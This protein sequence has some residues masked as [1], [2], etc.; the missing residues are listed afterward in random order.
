VI[1]AIFGLQYL[2]FWFYLIIFY[3]PGMEHQIAE[4]ESVIDPNLYRFHDPSDA[5]KY[6]L[7]GLLI[8]S[9]I[10]LAIG[11]VFGLRAYIEK[12]KFKVELTDKER[13]ILALIIVLLTIIVSFKLLYISNE[14]PTVPDIAFIELDE[15]NNSSLWIITVE[16]IIG[17]N[18]IELENTI[19]A[20]ERDNVTT[21]FYYLN[22][23]SSSLT[24][25][26]ITYVDTNNSQT[27]D[28]GDTFAFDKAIFN[29]NTKIRLIDSENNIIM[30]EREF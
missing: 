16:A 1:I 17:K 11:I 28:V 20:I 7:L 18:E 21:D 27:L 23:T 8:I 9:L 19:L 12:V 24:Y 15:V 5:L 25:R 29:E 22:Q 30:V 13:R 26:G 2:I 6:L 4:K 14:L 10:L 3:I